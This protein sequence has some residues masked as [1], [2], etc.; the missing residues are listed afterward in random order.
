MIIYEVTCE[1]TAEGIARYEEF[2]RTTHIRDVL[3]TGCFV[4][5]SIA[6]SMPGR[7]RV[8]YTALSLDVLDAYLGN[9]APQLRADFAAHLG[10]SVTVSREVWTE[11]QHWHGADMRSDG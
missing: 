2:M 7:Y 3:A 11:L 1:V 6:Q 8:R 9:H 5:A 4:R 10:T